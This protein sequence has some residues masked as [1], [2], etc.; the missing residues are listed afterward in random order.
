MLLQT[1]SPSISPARWPALAVWVVA[2]I[3][4]FTLDGRVGLT[5]LAMLLV[6]ACTLSSLWLST[7]VALVV[8]FVAVM[9]FGWGFVPPRYQLGVHMQEHVLLLTTTLAL[10]WITAGLMA[11][12]R[13]QAESARRHAFQAEQLRAFNEDLR[14][15]DDPQ[16]MAGALVQALQALAAGPVQLIMLHDLLPPA[17]DEAAVHV[18]G[19]PDTDQW[20]GLWLCLR[21]ANPFGPGT[22]RHEEVG[23]WYLPLRGRQGGR[24]AALIPLDPQPDLPQRAHAQALCDQLGTALERG[25]SASA[26]RRA[27]EEA[28][29]QAVRNT[30]LAAISHDFRTPLAT[31]MSAAS[32]LESQDE[33]LDARQRARL[34]R[35]IVEETA[36]L[37]RMTDNTLQLARLDAPGVVLK[38]DW[39]SVEELVGAVLRRL[40]QRAPHALVKARVEPHLPLIRCDAQLL[41]QLLDN[42]LD[43][44]LKYAESSAVEVLAKRD[45]EYVLVAVRDRGP[46]VTPAQRERI[47]EVFQRGEQ[48]NAARPDA[49][50][51]RGAGVGL[52]ACRAI[53]RAH[54]GEISYR[55]RSHGGAAIELR[56]PIEETPA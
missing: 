50:L 45:D 53:A 23:A 6:L 21:R 8:T 54:G 44:A 32:S 3:L 49:A 5:P 22:G 16:E 35:T 19:S 18:I 25:V 33:R 34:A 12:L 56:F 4:M 39:E 37:A 10:A 17:N 15:A 11:R 43:N 40:R 9:A 20:T 51:K 28:E 55:A 26:V 2:G 14:A 31:I 42:L 38:R 29:A 47:F 24:G 30:L 46:G 36:A 48:G 27:R 1:P 7:P 52:A 13:A 41:T